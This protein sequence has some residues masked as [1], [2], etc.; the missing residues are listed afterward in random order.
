MGVQK[1]DVS[2]AAG[3]AAVTYD[4]DIV[5]VEELAAMIQ[6][7]GYQVTAGRRD[8]SGNTARGAGLL[9]V[10]AA[11]YILMEHFGLCLSGF[12][13]PTNP[14]IGNPAAQESAL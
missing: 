9:L 7:L 13:A 6:K 4:A 10:I 12:T 5:S 8:Q 1:A 14:G 2:Y 3:T 11:L